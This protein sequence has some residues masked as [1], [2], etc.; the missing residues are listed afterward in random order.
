MEAQRRCDLAD[1]YGYPAFFFELILDLREQ[2]MP[3]VTRVIHRCFQHPVG[4]LGS[5]VMSVEL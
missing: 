3:S 2:P 1:E 4:T 5:Q